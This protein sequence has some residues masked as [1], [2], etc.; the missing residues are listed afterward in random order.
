MTRQAR[1]AQTSM[2]FRV[3]REQV[4]SKFSIPA[5]RARGQSHPF[6][7]RSAPVDIVDIGR[8]LIAPSRQSYSV[9]S[10]YDMRENEEESRG[11]RERATKSEISDKESTRSDRR[12]Y[13]EVS[14]GD[15]LPLLVY[16]R[17][18][19]RQILILTAPQIP[20]AHLGRLLGK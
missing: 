1:G 19:K 16:R 6:P 14:F 8:Y 11:V 4:E 13:R 9:N 20:R 2:I 15:T 3:F 10:V 5:G 18:K 17:G 7:V 12:V